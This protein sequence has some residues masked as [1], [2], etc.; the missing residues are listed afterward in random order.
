MTHARPR[1]QLPPAGHFFG[2]PGMIYPI[3]SPEY[4]EFLTV[5][6]FAPDLDGGVY[7]PAA[8]LAAL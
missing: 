1:Q 5:W 6:P 4:R 8:S 3:T 7:E 2:R